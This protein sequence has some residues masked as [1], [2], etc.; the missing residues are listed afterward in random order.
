MVGVVVTTSTLP[1]PSATISAPGSTYFTVGQSMRGNT[2]RAVQVT[3]MSQDAQLFGPQVAYGHTYLDHQCFF[4]E[5]GTHL[6]H[7][8]VVGPAASAGNVTLV[9]NSTSPGI[10]TLELSAGAPSIDPVTGISL[11]N[12]ID[13]G[14]WSA[15]L[16][17]Q[18]TASAL[19]NWYNILVFYSGAQVEQWGPFADVP[20]AISKINSSS[21]YLFASNMNSSST[22]ATANPKTLTSPVTLSA[23]SDDRTNVTASIYVAA[24]ALFIADLGSGYV[25]I[26]GQDAS[27]VGTGLISHA[28]T[29]N[30][31]AHLSPT[32]G[33][34]SVTVEAAAASFR[35][36]TGSENAGY[37]W[38]WVTIPDGSGGTLV[39]PPDGFVAGLRSRTVAQVGPWQAPAGSYGVAKFATGLDPA[40]GT[41][42]D[43]IGD[44]LNNESVNV[45]RPKGGIRLYGWRSLST[46][47]VNYALLSEADTLDLI[48]V[49]LE[50]GLQQYE[51]AIIDSLGQLFTKMSATALSILQPLINAGALAPGPADADG[52]PVDPGYL[53]DVGADVNNAQ[54]AAQNTAG[55]AVYVRLSGTAE[56]IQAAVIKVSL[57]TSFG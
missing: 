7:A 51:F 15:N 36:S 46:D 30:R 27:L 57:G 55:V 49:S 28:N 33:M 2:S 42:T 38:P 24:L 10:P 53:I 3:S 31:I 35:G 11:G 34:S 20:T 44:Q 23:G 43:A 32:Q 56:L 8:R 12:V 26:P 21:A 18:V 29:F 4:N 22:G 16:S 5:G 54:T 48:A 9:D 39:V 13:P 41:V 14:A 45:I 19:A 50:E 40:S 1:G 37:F 6:Y 25:A 52:N 47:T 17:V